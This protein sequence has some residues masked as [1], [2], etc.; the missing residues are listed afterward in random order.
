MINHPHV[1]QCQR[2]L[3]PTRDALIGHRRLC[4]ARGV[5]VRVMCLATFCALSFSA[6]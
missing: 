1:N 3:Q 2:L 6:R 5:V 4:P